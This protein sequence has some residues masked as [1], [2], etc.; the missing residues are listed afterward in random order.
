MPPTTID[1]E[2]KLTLWKCTYLAEI[3]AYLASRDVMRSAAMGPSSYDI[4]EH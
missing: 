3:S 1:I 4:L 2:F